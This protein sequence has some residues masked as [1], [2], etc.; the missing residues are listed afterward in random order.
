[1]LGLVFGVYVSG[2]VGM[3]FVVMWFGC[4]MWSGVGS[5][6]FQEFFLE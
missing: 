1:M 5:V 4:G 2:R 3:G 6:G